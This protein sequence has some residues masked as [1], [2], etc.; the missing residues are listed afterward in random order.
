M[1]VNPY[2]QYLFVF[3]LIALCFWTV[4]CPFL[5]SSIR[6]SANLGPEGQPILYWAFGVW[7]LALILFIVVCIVYYILKTKE[8]SYKVNNTYAVEPINACRE[9]ENKETSID[10]NELEECM[11]KISLDDS[12]TQTIEPIKPHYENVWNTAD[13]NNTD[14]LMFEEYHSIDNNGTPCTWSYTEKQTSSPSSTVVLVDK[15]PN[16][17]YDDIKSD[18]QNDVYDDIK[19]ELPPKACVKLKEEVISCCPEANLNEK[20]ISELFIYV[21]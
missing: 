1:E 7:L 17:P 9:L 21:D 13:G 20:R 6:V 16:E 15:I 11:E 3:I 4:T 5:W 2:K 14:Q 18:L 12:T 8:I 19:P 10:S